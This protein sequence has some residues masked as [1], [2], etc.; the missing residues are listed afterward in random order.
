MR[1]YI[2][3]KIVQTKK[4][5]TKVTCNKCGKSFKPDFGQDMQKIELHFGYESKYD[6][7]RWTFDLC[8][9]CILDIIKTFKHIPEECVDWINEQFE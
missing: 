8:D 3:E 9:E 1:D 4:I 7:D 5:N 6:T 2:E